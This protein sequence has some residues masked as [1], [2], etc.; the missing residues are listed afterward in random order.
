MSEGKEITLLAVMTL[1][2]AVDGAVQQAL[3]TLVAGTRQEPGCVEYA[4]HVHAGDPC[5]VFFYERWKDQAALDVHLAAPALTAFR[6][7][8]GHRLA[9]APELTFLHRLG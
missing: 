3:N 9:C 1:A 4:A 2:E 6:A 5:R 8:Q 7:E